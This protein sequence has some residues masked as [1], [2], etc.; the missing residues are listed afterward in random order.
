MAPSRT[1]EGH[2]SVALGSARREASSERW[3]RDRHLRHGSL[4]DGPLSDRRG[5]RGASPRAPA[6]GKAL[7][8]TLDR[9]PA[10]PVGV[11]S[12]LR[13]GRVEPLTV[14]VISLP[15]PFFAGS[16][17]R[18]RLRRALGARTIRSGA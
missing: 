4:S 6:R 8:A 9:P 12:R 17:R 16:R 1:E 5:P 3:R 7:I 13:A 15:Q 2:G 18:A 10:T 14:V 11:Q